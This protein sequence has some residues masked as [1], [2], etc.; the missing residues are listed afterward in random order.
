MLGLHQ[1]VEGDAERL[2]QLIRLFLFH[3]YLHL[4]HSITK[5]T[6]EEVGKF[7]NCLEYLD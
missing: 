4:Y 6:A 3:E 7:S 1:A 5:H 2:R